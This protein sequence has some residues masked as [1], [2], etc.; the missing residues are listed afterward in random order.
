MVVRP[1]GSGGDYSQ[2]SAVNCS[3]TLLSGER[4]V[5]KVKQP[6]LWKILTIVTILTFGDYYFSFNFTD[7]LNSLISIRELHKTPTVIPLNKIKYS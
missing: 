5:T 6:R 7:L 4:A 2:K 1:G 3:A